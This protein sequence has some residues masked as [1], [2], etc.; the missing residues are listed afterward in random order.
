MTLETVANNSIS[1]IL[2]PGY[3]LLSFDTD[4]P[5]ATTFE[6]TKNTG[7]RKLSFAISTIEIKSRHKST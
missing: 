3:N 5:P 1:V 7:E 4:V 2:V 6:S